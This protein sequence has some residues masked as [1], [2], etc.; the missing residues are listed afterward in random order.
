MAAYTGPRLAAPILLKMLEAQEGLWGGHYSGIATLCEGKIY[1]AKICGD[2]KRLRALTDAEKLPGTIGIAHT[3]TPGIDSDLWAHPFVSFDRKVV[4][5]ANGDGGIFKKTS[6]DMVYERMKKEGVAFSSEV[7]HPCS[8]YP[9]FPNGHSVHISEIM[10]NVITE[11]LAK[12]GNM[13]SA[14]SDAF[15]SF[16]AEIAALALSVK[17][18]DTVSGIRINQPLMCGR[19][20]KESFLATSALAFEAEKPDFTGEI[21]PL[22]LLSM[23]R[24][25]IIMETFDC[26]GGYFTSGPMSSETCKKLDEL[27]SSGSFTIAEM[28]TEINKLYPPGKMAV[29]AMTVYEYL[30]E[31]LC[32]GNIK[33]ERKTEVG[34]G[35]G[36]TSPRWRFSRIRLRE[37]NI[38]I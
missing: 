5:C 22:S 26:F 21:P 16:P 34:S 20:E 15:Q 13:R 38:P 7:P 27:L 3:R 2:V 4:Y 12:M 9:L 31:N 17:E 37:R 14:L 10:S 36:L 8:P 6:Y 33:M 11:N 28:V 24:S 25:G 23:S 32:S 1:C 30:R 18:P 35:R 29:S 19:R